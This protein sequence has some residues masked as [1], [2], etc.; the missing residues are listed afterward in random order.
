MHKEIDTHG[1]AEEK[2]KSRRDCAQNSHYSSV[3]LGRW[4]TVCDDGWG[5]DETR[6]VCRQ[7]GYEYGTP[8]YNGGG[9]EYG[10]RVWLDDV[11]CSGSEIR[12][13]RCRHATWGVENCNNENV[14]IV[15]R[16]Y[17]MPS[18]TLLL[19]H[20]ATLD[21]PR[22]MALGLPIAFYDR[23]SRPRV[24]PSTIFART[25]GHVCL[26]APRI[27][28]VTVP[29]LSL[30]HTASLSENGGCSHQCNNGDKTG[31]ICSCPDTALLLASDQR[32]CYSPYASIL[33]TSDSITVSLDK[34]GLAG[35]RAEYLQLDGP[36]CVARDTPSHIVLT[37][38]LHGCGTVRK[39]DGEDWVYENHL[40]SRRISVAGVV[41]PVRKLNITVHC[42]YP[43]R[44][45]V[46]EMYHVHS[47]Q[48][49]FLQSTD[50]NFSLSL[51][52]EH[53]G[54]VYKPG[55]PA[56]V[57]DPGA[58]LTVRLALNESHPDL[59]AFATNCQATSTPDTGDPASQYHLIQDGCLLDSTLQEN[60]TGS[61]DVLQ[62]QAFKFVG[63]EG[64]VF[65]HC[66][67][68]VCNSSDPSS[69]CQQGC[70]IGSGIRRDQPATFMEKHH[71]QVGPLLLMPGGL[72][73]G[74]A[75]SAEMEQDNNAEHQQFHYM[76]KGTPPS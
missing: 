34:T 41:S 36:G 37:L 58:P 49:R 64:A 20:M 61:D 76:P 42:R 12:L 17:R 75:T 11:A 56:L 15:C 47:E 46:D 16:E 19:N 62:I 4:G 38:P 3:R 35:L 29:H 54:H 39:D 70:V 48:L 55:G 51:E 32:T 68:L 65:L 7:L 45:H 60:R 52:L 26:P 59:Q 40:T 57:V 27:I 30:G 13:D 63:Q 69:R 43:R 2:D 23:D 9:R 74:G 67:V 28:T 18:H 22:K 8:S 10:L 50:G 24:K 14:N 5:L 21:G 72:L 71:V 44:V 1:Y 33:C 53:G 73:L 25:V 31:Y 66:D 6:V